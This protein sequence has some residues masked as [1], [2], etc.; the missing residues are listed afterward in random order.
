MHKKFTRSNHWVVPVESLRTG[1]EQHVADSSNHSLYILNTDSVDPVA[2]HVLGTRGS[3]HT[4]ENHAILQKSETKT[5]EF[6]S[7]S[8]SH[9]PS[10][11]LLQSHRKRRTTH[12]CV[13]VWRTRQKMEAT[14]NVNRQMREH[15]QTVSATDA[16]RARNTAKVLMW[17]SKQLSGLKN[18]SPQKN[19]NWAGCSGTGKSG[20]RR[21]RRCRRHHNWLGDWERA[22]AGLLFVFETVAAAGLAHHEPP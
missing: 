17:V 22:L 21:L 7:I 5:A 11:S 4:D 10:S 20:R 1:L 3:R 6:S 16:E 9:V 8:K 15:A 12:A 2:Q 14:W 13:V 18:S 19:R